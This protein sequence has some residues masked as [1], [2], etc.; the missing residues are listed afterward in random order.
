MEIIGTVIGWVASHGGDLLQIV[1]AL[2]IAATWTP[3]KSDDK[4]VQFLLDGVNFL[5]ANVGKAKNVE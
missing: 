4:F 5:G 1:G 3:N 2:A